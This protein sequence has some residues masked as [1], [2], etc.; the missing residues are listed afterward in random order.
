MKKKKMNSKS[1]LL[2]KVEH[3]HRNKK[4]IPKKILDTY[5]SREIIY[6]ARAINKQVPAFLKRH[7]EDY[8]ILTPSPLK[9]ARQTEK[10]LDKT[11]GG[12]YFRVEEAKHKGT[13]RVVDNIR[14]EA[15]ADYT[16]QETKVPFRRIGGKKYI[17]L[18]YVK[19][20]IKKTLRDKTAKYRHAKDRDSLNRIL[21]HEK[22]IAER[23]KKK[24]K[25]KTKYG[26]MNLH[27]AWSKK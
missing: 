19:D 20:H 8:D 23:K 15:V 14:D 9:D 3:F 22:I 25:L 16:K 26:F 17:K 4:K 2:K 18:S 12:D 6:G 10:A 24:A 21:I 27:K 11:F 13:F 7:T 5:D 1:R